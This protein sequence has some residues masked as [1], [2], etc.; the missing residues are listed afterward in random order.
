MM[1]FKLS[2]RNLRKSIQ[3]YVIYFATLILGVAIFYVFNA[4][5][6]QT[7][8]LRV[9]NDT[10]EII[11]LMMDVLS[12]VSVFVSFVLGF[13]VVYASTFL[14][15][16]R[17]R[18]F[19]IYML[20]GMSKRK[21]SG[22]LIIETVMIGIISLVIGLGVGIAVS[23]GM[24]IV[25]ANMFEADMTSFSFTVSKAA[26]VKTLIYF[27][28]MYVIVIA[29]NAIVVGKARLIT[30]IN[31]GKHSQK[32]H[33][34]NPV[35]CIVVFIIACALLGNAYYNVT[36]GLDVIRDMTDIG[37]QIV[38]GIIGTFMFFWSV[39]GLLIT[40]VKR[41]KRFYY[42]GLNCFSTK[43][44]SSRINTTVFSGGIICL[45]LFFTICILSSAM[46]IRKSLND[47]LKKMTPMDVQIMMSTGEAGSL[48][49]RLEEYGVD[50]SQLKNGFEI[51]ACSVDE[52]TVGNLAGDLIYEWGFDEDDGL[53]YF[54][55]AIVRLAEYNRLADSFN[56]KHYE[57]GEDEYIIVANYDTIVEM[58]NSALANGNTIKIAGREYKPKYNE[59]QD[60]FIL[61]SNSTSNEG[62]IIVPDSADL[63]SADYFEYIYT[64]DFATDDAEEYD[65]L[66]EYFKSDEFYDKVNPEEREHG[67][68]YSNT[69]KFICDSSIGMAAMVI[70]VGMYLGIV[71]LI[72]SAAILAL[73]EL[74]E[75]ADNREKYR[76]LRKIGVDEK[77]IS[78]SLM[79]QSGVFFGLPLALAIVHSVFGMQTAKFVLIMFGK[80]GMLYS[81]LCSAAVILAVYGIYFWITYAC[82][83]KIISE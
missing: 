58:Y 16:R 29:L 63:S 21:I 46:S 15:K 31:A 74:S 73:K 14:M 47:N 32:N 59:C 69:K 68:I 44:L 48:E 38:K 5:G 43:E 82:S 30:L 7:I 62:F 54:N 41:S 40:I 6:S 36:A 56:L 81:I 39:S 67:F 27:L 24:S 53:Q 61:M 42:K 75:A 77:Q 23:Q 4:L 28:V 2:A 76:I 64:A 19:G 55:I 80:G 66:S 49:Q 50:M 11:S 8:M 18:E 12:V 10:R 78:R 3:N 20:L 35:V 1:L 57:L 79:A 45:L 52:V 71:F 51:G 60:G 17:K 9:S 65:E 26:V 34:K 72:S 83:R 13:L 25:V 33:A 70:F 22:I 37:I